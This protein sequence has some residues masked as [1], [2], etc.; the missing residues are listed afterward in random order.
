MARFIDTG[1]PVVGTATG[2]A[3]PR[4]TALCV[5]LRTARAGRSYRGRTYLGGFGE[6]DNDTDASASSTLVTLGV[7]FLTAVQAAMAA[8]GWQMA[9]LSRPAEAYSTTKTITH[10]DGSTTV[11]TKS[12]PSRP[13][14]GTAVT[15]ITARND[16]WDSQRRR[17]APGSVSTFM[18]PMVFQDL[19]SGD[20]RLAGKAAA[21]SAGSRVAAR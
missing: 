10:A 8:S 7:A 18:G 3:L 4:G 17:S 6:G 21:Q 15:S 19:T 13:G 20:L 14:F 1:G 5:T 9:V 11:D 2:D 12:H 16:V